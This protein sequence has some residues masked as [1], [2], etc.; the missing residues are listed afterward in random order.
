MSE[1]PL[2]PRPRV[3]VGVL[4]L[5]NQRVLLGRRRGAHGAD[6]WAPPGGH[7]EFGESIEQCA[8][9]ELAEET[10]LIAREVFDGPHV[11][12]IFSAEALHYLTVFAVVRSTT[13]K[14]EAR[15]PEKCAAWQWFS[16]QQLPSPLFEPLQALVEGG[17]NPES[18]FA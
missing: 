5:D 18:V 6:T 14:A 2:G 13:G 8:A 9:R 15:E 12:T 1:A 11:N 17:F 7:L 10:G 16:W 4:V 3:G